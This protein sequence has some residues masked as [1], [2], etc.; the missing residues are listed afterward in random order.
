MDIEILQSE[1]DALLLALLGDAD[2][3]DRWWVGDNKG[4]G[5]RKPIDVDITEVH[6]Y[7]IRYAYGGW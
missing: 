5:G 4:F 6:E 3:V 2:L 1:C 7:L